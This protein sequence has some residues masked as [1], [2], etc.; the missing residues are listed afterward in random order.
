[1][2]TFLI[3]GA[4]E[5]GREEKFEEL[6]G[7][8]VI[9]FSNNPDFFFVA[10]ENSIGID[11]IR[12]L[13][14][15]LSLKPFREERKIALIKEAQIL[16]IEA[17]NALLKTL[18]EPPLHC[19]IYLTCPGSDWLLPT[20]VSR[21]QIIK[22]KETAKFGFD[23]KESDEIIKI[24]IEAKKANPSQRLVLVDNLQLGKDQGAVINWLD[25][26]TAALR[27]T[28]FLGQ[29]SK[30][31]EINQLDLLKIVNLINQTKTYLR[32]NCNVKLALDNFFLKMPFPT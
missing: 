26:L 31:A 12:N 22:L 13:E 32:A 2:Q 14:R 19:F 5:K 9:N 3:T 21:C 8:K 27:E 20:I 28:Y 4:D 15:N 18:E 11:Q 17:Q 29:K 24:V 7:Q 16:T 6:V 30:N 1:M 23:K 10:G 25:M